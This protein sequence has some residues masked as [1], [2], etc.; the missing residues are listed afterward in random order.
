MQRLF[1]T[2]RGETFSSIDNGSIYREGAENAVLYAPATRV[3][4]GFLPP[5]HPA[6]RESMSEPATRSALEERL[7]PDIGDKHFIEHSSI[8][9]LGEG[10]SFTPKAS[11]I[12]VGLRYW[13][14]HGQLPMKNLLDDLEVTAD[15]ILITG[16]PVVLEVYSAADAV[17]KVYDAFDARAFIQH[18]QDFR[19]QWNKLTQNRNKLRAA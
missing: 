16:V 3:L 18:A 12:P 17:V 2:A 5:D 11:Y 9:S 15:T 13:T 1:D 7:F 6:Y 10:F 4:A 19:K 8:T 14:P